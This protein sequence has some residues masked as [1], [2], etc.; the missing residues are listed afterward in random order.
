MTKREY[1]E[2]VE[3]THS[4]TPG[5][6][7]L[8]ATSASLQGK[9][10]IGCL[11]T[12]QKGTSLLQSKQQRKCTDLHEFGALNAKLETSL[13]RAGVSSLEVHGWRLPTTEGELLPKEQKGK[14]SPPLPLLLYHALLSTLTTHRAN[15]QASQGLSGHLCGSHSGVRGGDDAA[16]LSGTLSPPLGRW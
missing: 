4:T 14:K 16:T 15:Q 7:V 8:E 5:I 12:T 13:R 9:E 3:L 1:E 11:L 6:H 10:A 2:L